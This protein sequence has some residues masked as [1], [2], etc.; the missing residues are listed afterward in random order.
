VSRYDGSSG[1]KLH[2]IQLTGYSGSTSDVRLGL[3][4]ISSYGNDVHL[5][6]LSVSTALPACTAPPTGGL[7]VGN[8]YD[9]NTSA[10][11]V[12][13]TV[14]NGTSNTTTRS[15]ADPSVDEGLYVLFCA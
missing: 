5:D 2:S 4:G 7:A 10:T 8:A 9:A 1:W 13:A 12:G 3:L 11:L 6:D 15:T 14:D